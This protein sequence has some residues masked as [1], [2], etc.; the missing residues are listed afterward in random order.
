MSGPGV[1]ASDAARF[2]ADAFA[3]AQPRIGE[4]VRSAYHA[5]EL[6]DIGLAEDVAY[7]AQLDVSHVAPLLERAEDGVLRLRDGAS[8]PAR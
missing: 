7:C 8:P 2:A 1:I 5:Q 3:V 6:V 4:A